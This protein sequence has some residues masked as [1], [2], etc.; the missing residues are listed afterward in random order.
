MADF[1]GLVTPSNVSASVSGSGHIDIGATSKLTMGS[2]SST[3]GIQF[4]GAASGLTIGTAA[5]D[6]HGV[7]DPALS[8]FGGSDTITFQAL[9]TSA[10]WVNGVLTLLNGTSAVAELNLA[11]SYATDTFAVNN[12]VITLAAHT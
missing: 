3:L 5:L 11:G 1:F 8:G 7:F 6:G 4:L 10:N 12:G 9:I 2:G